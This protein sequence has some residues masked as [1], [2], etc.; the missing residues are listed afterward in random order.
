MYCLLSESKL[1]RVLDNRLATWN[2]IS[3]SLVH[4]SIRHD[5]RRIAFL[6]VRVTHTHPINTGAERNRIV[7]KSID[8]DLEIQTIRRTLK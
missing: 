5:E 3:R 4:Y 8:S 1:R 6:A 2:S 7:D